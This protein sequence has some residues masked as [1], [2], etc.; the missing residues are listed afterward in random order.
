MT[1]EETASLIQALPIG[2]E[3]CAGVDSTGYAII[4]KRQLGYHVYFENEVH[5]GELKEFHGLFDN[6][7]EAAQ[8]AEA[9]LM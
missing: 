4:I 8:K 3:H 9:L 7:L 1:T 2:G 6:P 5:F